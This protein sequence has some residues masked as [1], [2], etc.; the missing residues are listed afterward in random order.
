MTRALLILAALALPLAPALAQEAQ[1]EHGAAHEDHAGLPASV[2]SFHDVLAPDW[3]AE[4]GP[5]RSEA[6][7][8]HIPVYKTRARAI[9]ADDPPAGVD[10]AAWNA[11][12]GQLESAV[13][14]LAAS[15]Q[16]PGRAS[17]DAD[18]SAV[19]DRFHAVAALT[20]D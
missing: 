17:F 18:F 19:H 15:C 4:V 16:A 11:A 2:A 13:R 6:A 10:P 9:V 20:G 14:T 12:A 7:C 5:A 8:G 1:G 3:H